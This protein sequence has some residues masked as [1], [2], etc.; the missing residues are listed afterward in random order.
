ML[1]KKKSV[2]FLMALLLT[3]GFFSCNT[4]QDLVIDESDQVNSQIASKDGTSID[5]EKVYTIT[6]TTAPITLSTSGF[7]RITDVVSADTTVRQLWKFSPSSIDGSYYIDNVGEEENSRLS[8]RNGINALTLE[9][10]S[11]TGGASS[12]ILTP[13]GLGDYYFTNLRESENRRMTAISYGFSSVSY[14][15][16]TTAATNATDSERFTFTAFDL[17]ST[18]N[19][20][21]VTAISHASIRPFGTEIANVL[22]N[23]FD[24]DG[25]ELSLVSFTN[26]DS[27]VV[28]EMVGNSLQVSFRSFSFDIVEVTYVVSDGNGATSTGVL[29]VG[30][31]DRGN[32]G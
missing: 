18:G 16:R 10:S 17:P 8:T 23:D 5:T 22:S 19:R 1:H 11:A 14:G 29:R 30:R 28:I 20:A 4:D 12:W 2:K 25:D 3:S 26:T 6:S 9:D 15:A 27:R 21:P 13:T 31:S 32:N 24:P 7:G